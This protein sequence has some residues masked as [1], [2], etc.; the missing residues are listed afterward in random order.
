M[1]IAFRCYDTDDDQSISDQEIRIVLKNIPLKA[2]YVLNQR[3][4]KLG[5]RVDYINMKN[6]DNQQIDDLIETLFQE[7]DEDIFFDEF[8]TIA[9]E[10]TSELFVCIYD[11]IY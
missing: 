4:S 5:S 3:G 10:V 2:E 8:K 1:L 9:Q 6:E 7:L 11:C